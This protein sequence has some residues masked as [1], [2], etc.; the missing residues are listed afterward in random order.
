[1]FGDGPHDL[2]IVP[3]Y[4]WHIEQLWNHP[5]YHR[6]MRGLTDFARVINYDKRGTG[7]SDP[8]SS[9]PSLDERM[10]DILAV[11]DATGT[12][13]ATVLGISEGGPIGSMFA[14]T[15]PDRDGD[16]WSS[17]AHSYADWIGR[18]LLGPRELR[19]AGGR[20]K[21]TPTGIGAKA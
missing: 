21:T 9:A 17:T 18:T 10:D 4:V 11:L 8:I 7:M 2:V 20:S 19:S 5:G 15:H 13:R 16:A 6:M 3:G 1:M 12:E 14:A